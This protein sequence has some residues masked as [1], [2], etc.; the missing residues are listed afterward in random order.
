MRA[1]AGAVAGAY[2][3]TITIKTDS[4]L[5]TAVTISAIVHD[6]AIP[7]AGSIGAMNLRNTWTLHDWGNAA[8]YQAYGDLLLSYRMGPDNIY[9]YK[10]LA[11]PDVATLVATL[12]Y[13]YSLG[14]NT[15]SILKA[16]NLW[17]VGDLQTHGVHDFFSAL[18]ASPHGNQL[19]QMAQFYGYDE[20]GPA[21]YG[22]GGKS[23]CA[24]RTG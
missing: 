21:Y 23:P 24:P 18:A 14:L 15:F 17:H 19:R 5:D 4:G 12:E 20:K 3:G 2:T 7:A 9:R 8:E 16:D 6:F 10:P 1:P 22:D 11:P 13:W